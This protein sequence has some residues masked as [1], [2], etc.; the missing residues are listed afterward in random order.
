M[1]ETD[2]WVTDTHKVW[3]KS[4]IHATYILDSRNPFNQARDRERERERERER[5]RK[6]ERERESERKRI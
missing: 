6:K 3:V 1:H 4:R 2:F 5:K